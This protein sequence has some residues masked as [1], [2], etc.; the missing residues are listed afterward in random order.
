MK[1]GCDALARAYDRRRLAEA[2]LDE[3]RLAAKSKV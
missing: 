3:L 2:M 1:T